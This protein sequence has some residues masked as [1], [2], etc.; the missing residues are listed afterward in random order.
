MPGADGTAAAQASPEDPF[1]LANNR[2]RDAAKWLIGSSA[3]VGAVLIAGSQ[4][5]N[6]GRLDPGPRLALA[7]GAVVVGL[8]AVVYTIWKTVSLLP[9]VTVTITDLS[10]A[11]DKPDRRLKPAVDFFRSHPKYLQGYESPAELEEERSEFV[12]A[13]SDPLRPLNEDEVKQL[14][15]AI[16]DRDGRVDAIQQIAQ[17]KVLEGRFKATLGQLLVATGFVAAGIITFAWASN[18]KPVPPASANLTDARLTN[19][20]LR[21]ADLSHAKLDHVDFTNSDLTGAHLG[22]ASIFGVKWQNTICPDG[23]NSN[24]AGNS[25]AGHLATEVESE[26]PVQPPPTVVPPPPTSHDPP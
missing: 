14:N 26:E 22:G 18:P 11:W 4:L 1:Q 7:I 15:R 6:I 19:A 12:S 25:C 5:S 17:H 21:D 16:A 10:A 20:N 8:I 9:P 23:T 2:I 3:A 13:L 24:S